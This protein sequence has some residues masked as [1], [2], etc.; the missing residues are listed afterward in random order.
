MSETT[1]L[2]NML[3]ECLAI[4]GLSLISGLILG[5]ILSLAFFFIL[6]LAIGISGLR[7]Y[8]ILLS[9]QDTAMLYGVT[10]LFTL[11]TG[12]LSFFQTQ[13]TD[14][15][16][17]RY[18]AE[19]RGKPLRCL[20]F[21][22]I[23]LVI[24][25]VLIM[26][27]GYRQTN[28]RAWLV[29]LIVMFAGTALILTQADSLEHY[30]TKLAPDYIRRH[31]L[32]ISFVRHHSKSRSLTGIMAAWMIGFSVFFAGLCT[33]AY[34]IFLKDAITYSPYDLVYSQIFGKN[35]VEDSKIKT[36][37]Q[38]YSVSVKEIKQVHYL[39]SKV[40]TI[41]PLSEVNDQ[42]KCDYHV[43]KGQFLMVFQYD[44]NDGYEYD[45][46]T[47]R[48][49]SFL[50]GEETLELK[51]MGS[52]VRILFNDNPTFADW[53]IVLNDADYNKI[54]SECEECWAGTM[55]LYTFTNWKT[56]ARGIDSV[57]KYLFRENKID[58]SEEKYYKV[59]SK[60]ENYSS[61]KQSAEFF[62]FL[63]FF[64]EVL[65]FA[66]SDI[67]VFF[68]IKAEAEEEQRILSG[69]Y[70]IGVTKS[71]MLL[72]LRHKNIYYFMPQVILG[73]LIGVFYNYMV[74]AFYNYGWIA[75]GCALLAGVAFLAIQFAVVIN[76]SKSEVLTEPTE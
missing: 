6:R 75:A 4:A 20:F 14:L 34:P 61:N 56:S 31:I 48:T 32:E 18:R 41:L 46:T 25:S 33:I 37:L 1:V 53:T 71:E 69:L 36:L 10:I 17:E 60:I 62:I 2:K 9:Y 76:Y 16:K 7:W 52:D 67:I 47:P 44:L 15:I 72:I 22:G 59:T 26:I 64:I 58:P 73:L 5:T 65:F 49:T 13:L 66:A 12:I 24:V 19:K 55:K 42:L 8:L 51:N 45:M 57:E 63:M 38:Q 29:S 23:G 50:C 40:Y 28:E 21:F 70:R 27:T 68:K 74:N 30:I 11:L 54:A 35:Q 43:K 39:R 3:L